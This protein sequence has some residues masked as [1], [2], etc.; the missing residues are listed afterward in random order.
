VEF[1]SSLSFNLGC[2]DRLPP[3][4]VRSGH[5]KATVDFHSLNWKQRVLAFHREPMF[6]Q[7]PTPTSETGALV[8]RV[9][10]Q[11]R[12][13]FHS[14]YAEWEFSRDAATGRLIWTITGTRSKKKA[15]GQQPPQLLSAE[16]ERLF[17]QAF[18]G[19]R[20]YLKPNFRS[21]SS[22][23]YVAELRWR[24]EAAGRPTPLGSAPPSGH[25]RAIDGGGQGS[26]TLLHEIFSNAHS[27]GY[28]LDRWPDSVAALREEWQARVAACLRESPQVAKR[29]RLY[30]YC[31]ASRPELD[32][33]PVRLAANMRED[34]SAPAQQ[35]P[36]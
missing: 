32:G 4:L 29:V 31:D 23:R 2:P 26:G 12:G 21:T 13:C 36:A 14:Y 22:A 25:K 24:G 5:T 10:I 18:Y 3:L 34:S 27:D 1:H 7:L 16:D 9:V 17:E 15:E 8:V 19:L 6:Q 20:N 33:G 35:L 11:A 28:V 30:G